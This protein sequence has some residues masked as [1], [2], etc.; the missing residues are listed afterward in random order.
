MALQS[1]SILETIVIRFKEDGTIQGISAIDK[2]GVKDDSTNQWVGLTTDSAAREI[3]LADLKSSAIDPALSAQQATI[4]SLNAQVADLQKQLASTPTSPSV[5][6]NSDALLAK[7]NT[8]FATIPD[9]YKAQFAGEYAIVRVLVQ[10]DQPTLAAAVVQG[11]TIPDTLAD[12][13]TQILAALQ[14]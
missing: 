14:G 4:T 9:E 1:S 3:N 5:T 6:T 2:I 12:L 11:V 13:K 8:V 10:A 7:L